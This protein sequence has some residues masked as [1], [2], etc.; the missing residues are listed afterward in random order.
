MKDFYTISEFARLVGRQEFTIREWCRLGRI[1]AVAYYSGT[2]GGRKW[3][4]SHEE[5]LRY[6]N[7]G[8][9]PPPENRRVI[10][11]YYTLSEFADRMGHT[12]QTVWIWCR[13]GPIRAGLHG[14]DHEGRWEWRIP[15]DK[16]FKYPGDQFGP[17]TN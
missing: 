13:L 17:T 2:G 3:Q 5:L 16:P 14:P 4:I 15:R 11:G 10:R 12:A 9:L 8:L 1:T 6:R 7:A